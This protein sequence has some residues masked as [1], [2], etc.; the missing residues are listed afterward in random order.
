L[1]DDDDD[2]QHGDD[3]EDGDD[4]NEANADAGQMK[5]RRDLRDA[6]LFI[7]ENLDHPAD[8]KHHNKLGFLPWYLSLQSEGRRAESPKRLC[9]TYRSEVLGLGDPKVDNRGERTKQLHLLEQRLVDTE[10]ANTVLQV[11]IQKRD[12][13]FGDPGAFADAAM[14]HG[15][16]FARAAHHELGIR[17]AKRAKRHG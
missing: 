17:L 13:V 9:A 10:N 4:I 7:V 14:E 8:P 1:N 16:N 3:D 2:Q 15:R 5:Y 6:L 11:E 12:A